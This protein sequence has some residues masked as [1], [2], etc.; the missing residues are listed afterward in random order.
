MVPSRCSTKCEEQIAHSICPLVLAWC[1]LSSHVYPGTQYGINDTTVGDGG[2]SKATLS[3][4]RRDRL[5]SELFNVI[6]V[7]VRL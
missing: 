6:L 2:Y 5:D 7:G 4:S 1:T 3:S